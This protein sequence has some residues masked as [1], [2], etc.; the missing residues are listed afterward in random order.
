MKNMI[1]YWHIDL[2]ILI[3]VVVIT[4]SY[5][6]LVHFKWNSRARFF[7]SGIFIL[8][9]SALSPLHDIGMNYLFSAHMA[10]HVM[11]LMIGAPLLI[12]GIPKIDNDDHFIG[13]LSKKVA[14][15]PIV[16]WVAGVGIMWFWH[17]PVIFHELFPTQSMNHME[18]GMGTLTYLHMLSL[19]VAGMLFWWPI[20]NPY[21]KY[22]LNELPAVLYLTTACIGC[23]LLGLL[24]TFAPA[25][26]FTSHLIMEDDISRSISMQWGISKEMDQQIAGLIMWVPCCFI[27]VTASMV[28]LHKWFITKEVKSIP[29]IP[30][31][32]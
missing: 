18:G 19:L 13:Q 25:G 6:Y 14:A 4:F 32:N 11:I 12:L 29:L 31:V 10:S 15:F 9:L 16:C 3:F 5:L 28:L 8:I 1:T 20:I 26:L 21:A 30:K 17:V 7:L 24:I 23:S 2:L 22:R 27:Y